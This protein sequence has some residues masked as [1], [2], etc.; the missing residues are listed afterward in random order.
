MSYSQEKNKEYLKDRYNKQ[1]KMFID[2]LG[3]KCVVCE[4]TQN[5]EIDHIDWRLKSFNIG[6]LWGEK[7]L[8]KV[9]EELAKCQILCNIHH[10]EKTKNDIAE[11]AEYN[12]FHGTYHGWLNRKCRCENC[13]FAKREYYD[14]RNA[15]RRKNVAPDKRY[16]R[17]SDHGE[18]LH[19]KRGCRC[20]LCKSAN[21]EHARELK[22][23]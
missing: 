11:Q 13:D 19:Y 16:G 8:P 14:L 17:P 2:F 10:K 21:T 20:D 7:S 4:N 18:Y 23:K 6:V 9:F 15:R 1:R 3:G 22:N 12:D 5:L